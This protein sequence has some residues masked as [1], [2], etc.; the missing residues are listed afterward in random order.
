MILPNH[1]LAF[2][3]TVWFP[4][5]MLEVCPYTRKVTALRTYHLLLT[6]C[7]RTTPEFSGVRFSAEDASRSFSDRET[8]LKTHKQLP[9]HRDSGF[10][11][12]ALSKVFRN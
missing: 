1:Q 11:Q 2:T 5:Q 10:L 7:L 12:T 4:T 6:T 3:L 8:P 9:T